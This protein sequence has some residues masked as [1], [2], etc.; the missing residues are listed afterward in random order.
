MS[1][2]QLSYI[3][4][5]LCASSLGAMLA[6]CAARKIQLRAGQDE[7]QNYARRLLD[8]SPQ[9]VAE[10]DHAVAAVLNAH[11][12]FCSDEELAL[13]R[14]YVYNA[15]HVKHIGRISDGLLYCTSGVGRLSPAPHMPRHAVISI[16]GLNVYRIARIVISN[17]AGD[18]PGLVVERD[19]VSAVMNPNSYRALDESP[20]L[21]SGFLIDPRNSQTTLIFGHSVAI[22]GS[23]IAAGELLE[24]DGIFLRPLCSKSELICVVASESRTDILATN[25]GFLYGFLVGG[26][27]LGSAASLILILLDKRRGCLEQQLRRALRN[28]RLS[29]VYQP[30]VE[31]ES[32]TVVGA[33][34]L[35]RWTDEAG[36]PVSPEFFIALAEEKGFVGEIT[37]WVIRRVTQELGDVLATGNRTVTINVSSQDLGNAEFFETLEECLQSAG[38]AAGAIG[39]E[40][41]ER[42]TAD[43]EAAIDAVVR[44]KRTGH[45]VYVD[46]FGT[47]FSNLAYLHRLS[48]DAIKIDRVFTKMVGSNTA[49]TSIVPQILAMARQLGLRVVVEG[50]ETR[51]QA[52]YFRAAAGQVLAQGY[53]FSPGVPQAE[54]KKIFSGKV[55]AGALTPE[56][57]SA[58]LLDYAESTAA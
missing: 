23:E 16:D 24:R 2:R 56:R 5:F 4:L 52:E 40:I 34:A 19:G 54:I 12:A 11:L 55:L 33:E 26:A 41:T 8:T 45:T 58:A 6:Y 21:S 35:L 25:T 20:R 27:T 13:M 22:T 9:L 18:A 28:D 7:L 32:G 1:R 36:K 51:E 49:A 38:L 50:I 48:A 47:G 57:S 15:A 31:L 29:L 17:T 43:H 39:L 10:S 53:L 42:S 3:A 46:D 14:D 44:L 37:Q 30:I